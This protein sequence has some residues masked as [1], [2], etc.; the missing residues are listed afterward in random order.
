MPG[1]PAPAGVA[2]RTPRPSTSEKHRTWRWWPPPGT[3]AARYSRRTIQSRW[4]PGRTGRPVTYVRCRSQDGPG[5][6]CQPQRPRARSSF[7]ARPWGPPASYPP[8]RSHVCDCLS[9]HATQRRAAPRRAAAPLENRL[10]RA[11]G[12]GKGGIAVRSSQPGT[13]CRVN[14]RP[15][16]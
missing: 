15:P 11:Q 7:T 4:Y 12:K 10:D 13:G 6:S 14:G 1:R 8:P 2:S 3:H 9:A 16:R 5:P